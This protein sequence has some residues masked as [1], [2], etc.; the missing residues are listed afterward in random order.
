MNAHSIR[1]FE[2]LAP[3][4][5]QKFEQGGPMSRRPDEFV[6]VL[7]KTLGSSGRVLDFGCGSGDITMAC[8]EAGFSMSGVDVSPQMIER[9]RCRSKAQGIDFLLLENAEPLELPCE[10]ESF[11]AV[12]SSS[13]L[14]YVSGPLDCL[15]ELSRVAAPGGFLILTVPNMLHPQRWLEGFLCR[16]LS[17]NQFETGS[18]WQLYTE[19]LRLSRNRLRLKHWIALLREAGWQVET[20]S[21]RNTSLLMIVA[22]RVSA[23]VKSF[24]R[25]EVACPVAGQAS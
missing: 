25:H 2:R 13:V 9:A 24:S 20:V 21:A 10:P 11:N 16:V 23:P 12:I 14:E 6:N 17:P 18:K 1:H 19:Y 22:M 15:K 7:Q 4:W 3:V 8:R 5:E